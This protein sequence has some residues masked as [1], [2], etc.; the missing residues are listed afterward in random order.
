[1]TATPG[2]TWVSFFLSTPPAAPVQKCKRKLR[3][4]LWKPTLSLFING[5]Q[6]IAQPNTQR[7]QQKSSCFVLYASLWMAPRYCHSN[8]FMNVWEKWPVAKGSIHMIVWNN[9][10]DIKR[11]KKNPSQNAVCTVLAVLHILCSCAFM[12][13]YLSKNL[14][15]N[16]S[17]GD[18]SLVATCRVWLQRLPRFSA[19]E[20]ALPVL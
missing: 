5:P 20:R 4:L 6:S 1:M 11:K 14:C 17:L 8:F 12:M 16:Q 10:P 13:L 3:S 19:S 18:G 7:F 15:K 2:D 9:A